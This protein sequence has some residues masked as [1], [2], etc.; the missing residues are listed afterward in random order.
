[1]QMSV[2]DIYYADNQKIKLFK[3]WNLQSYHRLFM[4]KYRLYLAIR[5]EAELFLSSYQINNIIKNESINLK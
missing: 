1:M 5:Q 4:P 2:K 3:L